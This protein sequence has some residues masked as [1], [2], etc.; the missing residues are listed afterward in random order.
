MRMTGEP[1]MQHAAF[2]I[3]LEKRIRR[4]DSPDEAAKL[5]G[6]LSGCERCRGELETIR[7]EEDVLNHETAAFVDGFD[8]NAAEQSI[9]NRLARE[10]AIGIFPKV[11]GLL[12]SLVIFWPIVMMAGWLAYS[13]VAVVLIATFAYWEISSRTG[14]Q[15]LLEKAMRGGD[16]LVQAYEEHDR[17]LTK[18]RRGERFAVLFGCVGI[19]GLAAHSAITGGW[20]GVAFA[21]MLL[22]FAWT[23][24]RSSLSRVNRQ[25]DGLLDR[26]EISW[27]DYLLS[28]A[29]VVEGET[30]LRSKAVIR[31]LWSSRVRLVLWLLLLAAM[32]VDSGRV[33][34]AGGAVALYFVYRV[35]S[36]QVQ[37][38]RTRRG[39]DSDPSAS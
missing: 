23:L 36:K 9:R 25:R 10:K 32:A 37:K 31:S 11:F 24:A 19:V 33:W 8:W 28:S 22:D 3:L 30:R 6:H 17:E 34:L 2:E 27:R 18:E 12:V 16:D 20:L 39:N 29:P 21:A 35:S 5:D 7:K 15:R 1:D 38:L 13:A 26:G 4:A 14:T